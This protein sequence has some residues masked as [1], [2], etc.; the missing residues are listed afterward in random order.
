[1]AGW[2]ELMMDILIDGQS[3][4]WNHIWGQVMQLTYGQT[5]H[6]TDGMTDGT[7]QEDSLH[8]L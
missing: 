8:V 1:M 5:C 7:S 6:V 4:R 3:S 2:M